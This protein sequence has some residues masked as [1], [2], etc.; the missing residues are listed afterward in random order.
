M[1]RAVRA[2]QCHEDANSTWAGDA[3][4]QHGRRGQGGARALRDAR[5]SLQTLTSGD[6]PGSSL[7]DLCRRSHPGA[8]L[9]WN[10]PSVHPSVLLERLHCLHASVPTL[11]PHGQ[12]LPLICGAPEH[13][14]RGRTLPEAFTSQTTAVTT[15]LFGAGERHAPTCVHLARAVSPQARGDVPLG[16]GQMTR[17]GQG[18]LCARSIKRLSR[19]R[20]P[21]EPEQAPAWPSDSQLL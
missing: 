7:S 15:K 8:R 16:W 10:A 4:A 12:G 18:L 14:C 13:P 1:S 3:G 6:E 17:W 5:V 21:S 19:S 2:P 11:E 20:S 9:C